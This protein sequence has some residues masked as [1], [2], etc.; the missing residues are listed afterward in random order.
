MLSAMLN[1][2]L[3]FTVIF[4]VN[5]HL[6]PWNKSFLSTHPAFVCI[7]QF[8]DNMAEAN[9]VLDVLSEDE[10]FMDAS[11]IM[12]PAA[13]HVRYCFKGGTMDSEE[14]IACDGTSCAIEWFHQKCVGF[15]D[16]STL[17]KLHEKW[18]CPECAKEESKPRGKA[19]K[20]GKSGR[21]T[22]PKG[23]PEE[24]LEDI[25][26]K[27]M[28]IEIEIAALSLKKKEEE[29]LSL[30]GALQQPQA[31]QGQGA[32][33]EPSVGQKP[34]AVQNPEK[35]PVSLTA[36]MQLLK[37]FT[38][39]SDSDD[40]TGKTL[41]FRNRKSG[42]YKTKKD[43]IRPSRRQPW[44][45][46]KLKMKFVSHNVK[47]TDL[48]PNLFAAGEME[49][50]LQCT[51]VVEKNSRLEFL[52][53]L[54]Y[55]AD[56]FPFAKILDWYAAWVLEIEYGNKVWGDDFTKIGDELL[57]FIGTTKEKIA[58]ATKS[59]SKGARKLWCSAFQR[60]KCELSSPHQTRINGVLREVWHMCAAC[61]KADKKEMKHADSS[62][63]CPHRESDE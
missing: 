20:S 42:F 31:T 36:A 46:M 63:S 57:K 43:D 14:L 4:V 30:R 58:P 33:K 27:T 24:H 9:P 26:R 2:L 48:T 32:L 50:I 10:N 38:T 49:I 44:P 61:W 41:L 16:A 1:V 12:A 35:G 15:N 29:L 25:R 13:E 53:V 52:R 22:R 47:F 8:S 23:L 34:S 5:W 6:L 18:F 40:E 21:D 59:A 55:H 17:P 56:K 51:N 54:L 62:A 45:H 60:E 7:R 28:E 3:I 19:G 11:D 39:D 37:K